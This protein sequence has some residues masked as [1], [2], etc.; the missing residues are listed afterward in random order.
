MCIHSL[1]L[2]G[3]STRTSWCY[4]LERSTS[5][6]DVSPSIIR[7][8]HL[9]L[10]MWFRKDCALPI[11]RWIDLW[12]QF[13]RAFKLDLDALTSVTSKLHPRIE[14]IW[15]YPSPMDDLGIEFSSNSVSCI[16][17]SSICH[18]ALRKSSQ[19]LLAM[20]I[21]IIKWGVLTGSKQTDQ[22]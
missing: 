10:P 12:R 20:E 1:V 19:V 3:L 14:R 6:R 15:N 13:F 8:V 7:C 16:L 11:M 5:N 22:V 9:M 21:C 2:S 18:L 4:M 17:R